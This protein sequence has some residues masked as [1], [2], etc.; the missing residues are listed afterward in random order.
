MCTEGVPINN[1]TYRVSQYLMEH[2][3]TWMRVKYFFHQ[4]Y[5]FMDSPQAAE[6]NKIKKKLKM[7]T[8]TNMKIWKIV[9]FLRKCFCPQDLKRMLSIK[10]YNY[11]VLTFWCYALIHFK[12]SRYSHSILFKR[13]RTNSWWCQSF[14]RNILRRKWY[15]SSARE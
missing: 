10:S 5:G 14:G 7:T 8:T 11:L 2:M 12:P 9:I 15:N 6:T 3:F 13:V 1:G 4:R